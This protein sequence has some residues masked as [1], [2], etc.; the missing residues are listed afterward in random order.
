MYNEGAAGVTNVKLADVNDDLIVSMG[1]SWV[2]QAY[3]VLQSKF[4]SIHLVWNDDT[5]RG[6]LTLQYTNDQ[7][8]VEWIDKDIVNVDGTFED[9]LFID[10]DITIAAFRIKFDRTAGDADLKSFIIRKV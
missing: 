10:A 7:S 2:S 3:R 6:M 9:V 1:A 4:F 5:P 8:L